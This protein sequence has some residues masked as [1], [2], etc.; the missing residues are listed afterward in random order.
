MNDSKPNSPSYSK[1]AMLTDTGKD[2][3]SVGVRLAMGSGYRDNGYLE[4]KG[5]LAV[6]T[7][8]YWVLNN[9]SRYGR[10]LKARHSISLIFECVKN[11]S[12]KKPASISFHIPR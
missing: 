6:N 9:L 8:I 12:N 5:C 11:R 2:A 1:A 10:G 7:G 3:R 4:Y